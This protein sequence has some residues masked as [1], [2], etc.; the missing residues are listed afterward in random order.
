MEDKDF[1]KKQSNRDR[2][3]ARK[4]RYAQER[5]ELSRFRAQQSAPY[6]RENTSKGKG[7]GKA[8]DQAGQE[9]LF[10]WAKNVGTRAGLVLEWSARRR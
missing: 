7:K 8:R 5:E 1:R 3:V 9:M 2:R 4:K 10:S 6:A